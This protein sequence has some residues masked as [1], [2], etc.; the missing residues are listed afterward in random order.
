MPEHVGKNEPKPSSSAALV[1]EFVNAFNA[2]RD[3]MNGTVPFRG[4]ANAM[5]FIEYI[6]KP[7]YLYQ[8]AQA[9]KRLTRLLSAEPDS[10]EVVLPWGLRMRIRPRED[11]GRELWHKGIYDLT[12]CEALWRLLDRG[13]SAI[14][15]GANVGYTSGLMA[16]RSGPE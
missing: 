16:A 8:P 7:E 15:V 1:E 4:C 3:L 11:L 2:R 14:D 10:A 6:D 5:R 12:L 9:L 13:E